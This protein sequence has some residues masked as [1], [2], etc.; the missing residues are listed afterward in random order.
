V[1]AEVDP[2]PPWICSCRVR[3]GYGASRFPV[4]R[5]ER[6]LLSPAGKFWSV[7]AAVGGGG[8]GC[9]AWGLAFRLAWGMHPVRISGHEK[10]ATCEGCGLVLLV[11]G[12]Q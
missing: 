6:S 3:S 11:S 8:A 7:G 5:A 10:A 1:L 2:P 12:Q 4:L 9:L